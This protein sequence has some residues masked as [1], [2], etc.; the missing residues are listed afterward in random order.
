MGKCAS[1]RRATDRWQ[2]FQFWKFWEHPLYEI[3]EYVFKLSLCA[4]QYLQ[5]CKIY[6][7]LSMAIPRMNKTW[8]RLDVH[9]R[10][11]WTISYRQYFLQN[12][13]N[14]QILAKFLTADQFELKKTWKHSKVFPIND[15]LP[16][17]MSMLCKQWNYIAPLPHMVPTLAAHGLAV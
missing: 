5:L 3:R 12:T 15:M 14:F 10:P 8:L 17:L 16:H 11:F 7:E 9:C 4:C 2:K 6:L 13:G 1:W